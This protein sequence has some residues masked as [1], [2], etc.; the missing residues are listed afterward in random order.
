[1]KK[2]SYAVNSAKHKELRKYF[3]ADETHDIL[4]AVS[5]MAESA[6]YIRLRIAAR[7]M[8]NAR[9]TK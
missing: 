2:T 6:A 1:M 7:K 9:G 8:R 5:D 4:T 3:N